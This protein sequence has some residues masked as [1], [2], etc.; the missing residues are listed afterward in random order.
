MILKL[1]NGEGWRFRCGGGDLSVEESVYFGTGS[2]RRTE[3][4]VVKGAV[5]AHASESAWVFEQVG[6]A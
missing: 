5:K 6:S 1:P 3:Q 4:I 2:A